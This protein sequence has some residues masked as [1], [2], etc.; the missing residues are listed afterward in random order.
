V[1]ALRESPNETLRGSRIVFATT[2]QPQVNQR[3]G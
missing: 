1:E 2:D 3:L